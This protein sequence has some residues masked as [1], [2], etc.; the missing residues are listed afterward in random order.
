MLCCLLCCLQF[1][2]QELDHLREL[3]QQQCGITSSLEGQNRL[4]KQQLADAK[5]EWRSDKQQMEQQLQQLQGE[6]LRHKLAADATLV[7]KQREQEHS[8]TLQ[9]QL[10]V[11]SSKC[12][13]LEHDNEQLRLKVRVVQCRA[14][15]MSSVGL[16]RHLLADPF[17]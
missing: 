16:P 13:K 10:E 4:L 7:Q 3:Y 1:L 2:K 6:A 5:Q 14:R 12:N 9:Q 11:L 8:I 15:S 17:F